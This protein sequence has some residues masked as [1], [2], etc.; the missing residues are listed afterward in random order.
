[1]PISTETPVL[2]AY[3]RLRLGGQ[4]GTVRLA[5]VGAVLPFSQA[6]GG[7]EMPSGDNVTGYERVKALGG[8]V[9][10]TPTPLIQ[11]AAYVLGQDYQQAGALSRTAGL[12]G[13]VRLLP[14]EAGRLD[15]PSV[16]AGLD[17]ARQ[18]LAPLTGAYTS[19]YD[20]V[21][22]RYAELVLG[23]TGQ[24]LSAPGNRAYLAANTPEALDL[25]DQA[26]REVVLAGAAGNATSLIS[27]VS[28]TARGADAQRIAAAKAG[29]YTQA[30][31]D[32][33]SPG[34][35]AKMREFNARQVATN[36]D[37]GAYG[38]ASR[39]ARGA[40]LLKDWENR[41]TVLTK[42]KSAKERAQLQREAEGQIATTAPR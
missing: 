25:Y 27:P 6:L 16:G 7:V 23:A 39:S 40:I 5:P 32:G 34:V 38:G 21:M 19:E 8:A 17:A 10:L 14:G 35:A 9:G 12:E 20:P 13:L 26:K 37:L 28:V 22:R 3:A 18:A 1:M 31:I 11:D 29:V 24:P 41:T 15:V 4:A 2:G 36:P 42:Y 33:S 30:Q